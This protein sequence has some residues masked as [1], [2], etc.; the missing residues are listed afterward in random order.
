MCCP[1][2]IS[3]LSIFSAALGRT[4][5]TE[6][7]TVIQF[8]L[9]LLNQ[10]GKWRAVLTHINSCSIEKEEISCNKFVRSLSI[11]G[12]GDDVHV[13]NKISNKTVNVSKRK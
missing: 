4:S 5:Y 8:H 11:S 9:T 1:N 6:M 13:N 3:L 12:I 2:L 10:R 7:K